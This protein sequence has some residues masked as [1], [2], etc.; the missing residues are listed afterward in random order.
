MAPSGAE[1]DLERAWTEATP[2]KEAQL[3]VQV[4]GGFVDGEIRAER[5]L[6]LEPRRR[7][8]AAGAAQLGVARHRM[9][10]GRDRRRAAAV[11]R[12]AAATDAAARRPRQ[13]HRLDRLQLDRPA[14]TSS[15]PRACASWPSATTLIG[16]A[17]SV[18]A[19]ERRFLDAL[20]AVRQAQLA[21]TDARLA[22]R[23]RQAAPAAR[24]A[25]P[26]E[27]R[28]LGNRRERNLL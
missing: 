8:P 11:R 9:A 23:R 27:Q 15:I 5:F 12:L 17:P 10:G 21:G 7:L 13:V 20:G 25:R 6:S 18:G 19:P 3:Y 4:I 14:A 24:G 22:G 28:P 1:P 2:S 26:L 16:C